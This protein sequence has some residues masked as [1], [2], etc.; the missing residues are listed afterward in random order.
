MK[1]Y[2]FEYDGLTLS[3]MGYMICSFDVD[4]SETVS[5]GSQITFNTVPTLNGYKHE[6]LSAK[7]EECLGATIQICKDVCI[8]DDM[9]ISVDELRSLMSWLN[10]KEFH[11]FKLLDDDYIDLYFEASFN[12][13]K[14]LIAGKVCG[15]ELS[16][17]TNRPFALQEPRAIVIN[18]LSENG[19]KTLYDTS[20]EEGYIYPHMEITINQSG[21]LNIHNDLENRDMY[22]A[23]C[24]SGETITLDYPV[25]TSS[26]NSHEIQNDFNWNFFRIANTFRN[27]KN[28]LTIS[29][30]CTI[31]LSYS[32]IVKVTV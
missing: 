11:K 4:G 21:N 26:L 12:V 7:Y 19:K 28:D 14:I 18:N 3:D 31:K 9:E 6:L 2:D 27:K 32:P 15:L 29:L 17:T 24:T 16:M 10:R 25:I 20:D 13:N 5:N 23:N 22:I 30:P 1:C 8:Y